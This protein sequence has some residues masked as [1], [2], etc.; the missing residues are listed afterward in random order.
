MGFRSFSKIGK[1]VEKVSA[2]WSNVNRQQKG[3]CNSAKVGV[4]DRE[5]LETRF[6]E[7]KEGF[8]ATGGNAVQ[9]D[10][11][12]LAQ[13]WIADNKL[14]KPRGRW[15]SGS[16]V[17]EEN[18]YEQG[19]PVLRQPPVSQPV[20]GFLEPGSP[21]ECECSFVPW[22]NMSC[23]QLIEFIIITVIPSLHCDGK[24]FNRN[25]VPVFAFSVLPLE[26]WPVVGTKVVDFV[27]VAKL[28]LIRLMVNDLTI[29]CLGAF[30]GG[31]IGYKS[32]KKSSLDLSCQTNVNGPSYTCSVDLIN[33]LVAPL[34]ARSNLLINRDI[35]WAN[36]VLGF[37]KDNCY[38]VVD[39]CYPQSSMCEFSGIREYLHGFQPRN[40]IAIYVIEISYADAFCY[41]LQLLRLRGPFAY[42]TD[43]MCNEL[44]RV[45]RP[46][47]WITSSIYA[48]INVRGWHLWRR[49]YDLYLKYINIF[50]PL[51]PPQPMESSGF[52][53]DIN[54]EVLAEIDHDWRGFGVEIQEL[55]V[56][57][58]LNL[59]ERAV[60][61]ALVI[62]LDND[63]FSRHGGW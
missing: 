22:M 30:V 12:F 6:F 57:R 24:S 18:P 8:R 7:Q 10:R 63:Y 44:S 53:Y 41:F 28:I 3:I 11:D 47:W 21:E 27:I 43:V 19:K 60:T 29:L 9:L 20:T 25:H 37:E 31:L 33:V 49:V 35:E 40:R 59:L 38:A 13:F 51:L 34:L 50:S 16:A 55:A 23:N 26:K 15:F 45:C 4:F 36:L 17:P 46:F 14:E 61:V 5:C 39:V 58:P 42:I 56:A 52:V 62:S 54:G 1:T 2:F 48:E 32:V